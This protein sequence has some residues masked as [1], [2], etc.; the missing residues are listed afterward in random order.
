[1][2]CIYLLYKNTEEQND[3]EMQIVTMYIEGE[4]SRFLF[5][6]LEHVLLF[7]PMRFD[8]EH[9]SPH[10]SPACFFSPYIPLVFS[11]LN[12]PVPSSSPMRHG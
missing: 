5:K 4:K 11:G 2:G 8:T 12:L 1:M 3:R 10:V 6:R 7:L 9:E